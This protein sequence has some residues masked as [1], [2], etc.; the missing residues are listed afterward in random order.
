MFI[1]KLKAPILDYGVVMVGEVRTFLIACDH[2][3]PSIENNGM[4]GSFIA[5]ETK[6]LIVAVR[7]NDVVEIL[8]ACCDVDWVSIGYELTRLDV[9]LTAMQLVGRKLWRDYCFDNHDLTI[10]VS[11]EIYLKAWK[12]VTRSNM[13]KISPSGKVIKNLQG[14]VQKPEGWT[15]PDLLTVLRQ[16]EVFNHVGR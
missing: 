11:D 13:A 2:F 8:D 16:Y 7:A 9:D 15:A 6:E 14:K 1:G 4:Y 5:S 3:F 10:E 12:E